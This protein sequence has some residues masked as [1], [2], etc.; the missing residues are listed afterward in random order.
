MLSAVF[1]PEEILYSGEKKEVSKL[2]SSYETFLLE[3]KTT[4]TKKR[5]QL[6]CDIGT[7]LPRRV[8][9]ASRLLS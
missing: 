3:K 1:F 9:R 7:A 4:L 5:S 8:R 2:T 6:K